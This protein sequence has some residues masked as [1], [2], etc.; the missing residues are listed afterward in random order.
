MTVLVSTARAAQLAAVGYADNPL[1]LW[2]N[3]ATSANIS[4][5]N[6]DETD[7][8]ATNAVNGSTWD[9]ALPT[10][11]ANA[12]A[13][14]ITGS[15][16]ALGCVGLAAHN[17]GTLGATVQVRYSDDGGSSWI[18][19]GAGTV[20]PS[21]DQAILWRFAHQAHDDWE[22][23]ITSISSGQ[24]QVGVLVMGPELVVPQRLY[25]GYAPPVTPTDVVLQANVSEGG[26]LLGSAAIRRSS[27]M[28]ARIDLL[29]PSFIRGA[30]WSGFQAHHNDG[31]G[32]F[33][34]WRPKTY[35]D[36]FYGWRS[37]GTLVP[38]NAGPLDLMAFDLAM[39]LY[40]E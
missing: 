30:A 7:G 28:Q 21:D 9:F 22:L 2:D 6:G 36:A 27:R 13:L 3:K 23:K 24:P 5:E 39:R 34:A 4:S 33:W 10:V 11:A 12:A 26:H 40:D 37:G 38:E 25:Q 17:L 18:D 20:S 31:G 19:A 29:E 1:L 35:G 32:S 15:S 14:Q 8:A 16:I